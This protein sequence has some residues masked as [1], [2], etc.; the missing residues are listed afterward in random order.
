M[1][2]GRL[3]ITFTDVTGAENVYMNGQWGMIL[4]IWK[5]PHPDE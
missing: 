1:R 2:G 4:V 3:T 5:V